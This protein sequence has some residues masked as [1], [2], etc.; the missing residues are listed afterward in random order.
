[1]VKERYKTIESR[2]HAEATM[3]PFDDAPEPLA[4]RRVNQD[5]KGRDVPAMKYEQS[6]RMQFSK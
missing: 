6:K 3:I 1:M 2:I 5:S 4:G